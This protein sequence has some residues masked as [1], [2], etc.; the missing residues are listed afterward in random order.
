MLHIKMMTTLAEIATSSNFQGAVA[1][2]SND[3]NFASKHYVP[4]ASDEIL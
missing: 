3:I 4:R 2:F 1:I